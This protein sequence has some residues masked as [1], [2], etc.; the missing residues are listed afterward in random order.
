MKAIY[1]KEGDFIIAPNKI[2][3]AFTLNDPSVDA[4]YDY[5]SGRLIWRAPD[6]DS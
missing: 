1:F 6:D 5:K 2:A 4:V 3:D